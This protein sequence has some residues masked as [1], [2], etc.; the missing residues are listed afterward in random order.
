MK[1]ALTSSQKVP[2][3]RLYGVNENGNSILAHLYGYVPYIY[4]SAPAGVKNSDLH[5]FAEALNNSA[6][7]EQKTKDVPNNIVL[8]IKIVTKENIY[9]FHGNKKSQ[10]LQIDIVL[11]KVESFFFF[12][13]LSSKIQKKFNFNFFF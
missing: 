4:C 7:N 8:D 2:I 3:F 11:P 12:F 1:E 5:R 6:K 10:F 9:G 13:F